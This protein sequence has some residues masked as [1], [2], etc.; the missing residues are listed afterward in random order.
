MTSNK[1]YGV[2][3]SYSH[4]DAHYIE[5]IVRVIKAMRKDLVFQD[6]NDIKAGKLG[7]VKFYP[8]LIKLKLL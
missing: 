1:K 8:L 4:E 2:F 7:K 6:K 5:A 3:I